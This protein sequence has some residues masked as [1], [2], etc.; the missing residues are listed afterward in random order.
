MI[1][2]SLHRNVNQRRVVGENE[3]Q[4]GGNSQQNNG[5]NH[6]SEPMMEDDEIR[7]ALLDVNGQQN[8]QNQQLNAD[9]ERRLLD[10]SNL[11]GLRN[12]G[13]NFGWNLGNNRQNENAAHMAQRQNNFM[14]STPNISPG[15]QARQN[16]NF[17]DNRVNRRVV[18]RPRMRADVLFGLRITMS[19]K[20]QIFCKIRRGTRKFRQ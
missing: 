1:T 5:N 17:V 10:Q 15:H 19:K 8:E 20:C 9:E 4:N 18:E 16:F 12:L 3:E 14:T 13:E 7:R 6:H 11:N 2:R